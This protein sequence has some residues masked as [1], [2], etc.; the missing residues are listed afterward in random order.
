MV[1][2]TRA[3]LPANKAD[4]AAY[5]DLA[6]EAVSKF[7]DEIV[8][9]WQAVVSLAN[10]A[11]TAGETR[12]DI[13][14]RFF[15]VAEVV[16]DTVAREKYWDRDEVFS[17]GVRLAPPAALAA[18]SRWRDRR[19]GFLPR[20][21]SSLVSEAVAKHVVTA[22]VGWCLSG[23]FGCRGSSEFAA[24]C[25]DKANTH[26]LKQR[27]LD[28]AIVDLELQGSDE[29][30]VSALKKCADGHS[31]DT[32]QL[33]ILLRERANVAVLTD[34][35]GNS[36]RGFDDAKPK[37]FISAKVLE[38]LDLATADGISEAI[39]RFDRLD[40]RIEFPSFWA[41]IVGRILPGEEL[42]FLDALLAAQ[43][44]DVYDVVYALQ[45]G[46]AWFEQIAI[47]RGLRLFAKKLGRR[48]PHRFASTERL[49]Y[50]FPVQ[51]WDNEAIA[52]LR[53]GAIEGLAESLEVLPAS[54]LFGFVT[55]VA[56]L[57]APHEAAEVLEFGISRF[58]LHIASDYGDG[59]WAEWLQPP[60]TVSDALVGFIWAALGSP[61]SAERWQAAHCVRRLVEFSCSRELSALLRWSQNGDV[62][63]FGSHRFPFYRLH[64]TLYLLI[65]LS[66]GAID[67]P[68]PLL[69]HAS[70]LADMA[71]TGMPHVL[72]Q[73][74][75]ASL[76]LLLEKTSPG[77]YA[78]GVLEGLHQ[79]G[80]SPF[81]VR[82]VEKPEP[83]SISP[84]LFPNEHTVPDIYLSWDFDDYWFNNLTHLFA[85]DRKEV[86][87][88]AKTIAVHDLSVR[89]TGGHPPD[90]RKELWN[91]G[92]FGYWATSP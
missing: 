2:A 59:E 41:E 22:D 83:T 8:E 92:S 62:A 51:G 5:L 9:R 85:V 11:A 17:V 86:I 19:V 73:R 28:A 32:H 70:V 3:V 64:A 10:R 67:N 71:L 58:E 1:R 65:G 37:E 81:P 78:P 18:L 7:G 39:R 54:T 53:Q 36:Q 23:F 16:G 27:I 79:V 68:S 31:L 89:T 72:I 15:R 24:A 4:S 84:T 63:A 52:A 38:G 66:R 44:A 21:L 75:S 6:I 77:T 26:L 13:V 60:E 40:Q 14:Y 50:W 82:E 42:K 49:H 12:A 43:T 76:A 46:K 88:S 80:H 74:A 90:G 69:P 29:K 20:Q 48:F 55:S 57:L 33:D 25:I 30:E 61:D 47:K 34:R 56:D 87:D 35:N 45:A 91:S